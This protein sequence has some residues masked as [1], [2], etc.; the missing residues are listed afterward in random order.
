[1]AYAAVAALAS[2]LARTRLARGFF[3]NADAANINQ[4]RAYQAKAAILKARWWRRAARRHSRQYA[5]RTVAS[6]ST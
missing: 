4:R 5:A 3:E 2:A 6:Q 1:V